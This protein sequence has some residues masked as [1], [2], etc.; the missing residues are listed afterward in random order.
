M[1]Q[2]LVIGAGRF[3]SGIVKELSS[4]NQDVVVCDQ[5][6]KQLDEIDH[7]ATHCIIGD[8]RENDIID[9]LNIEEFD[10]VFVA[11]GSDAFSAIM[12]TKKVKERNA[13]RIVAKA[14]TT[15]VGEILYSMGADRVIFP[16]EE[17]GIKIARQ[18]MMTGVI[19]YL[20]ITKNVSAVEI[21]VP[22]Q[23]YGRTLLELDFSK[24]FDLTVSLIIREGEPLL[25]HYAKIPFKKGDYILLIGENKKIDRFKKNSLRK[26]N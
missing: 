5:N 26:L 17:A 23:L 14:I 4:K 25:V 22:E 21:E 10:T 12:I 7:Y 18:E 2:Y 8:F 1:K 24:R 16:E 9:E 11:I 15:E 13:K 19:E 3:G 6:E 20:E